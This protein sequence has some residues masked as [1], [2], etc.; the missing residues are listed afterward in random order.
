MSSNT[1]CSLQKQGKFCKHKVHEIHSG[2]KSTF[3]LDNDSILKQT[4]LVNNLEV[5]TT[6][7]P[8]AVTNTLIHQ[9][10]NCREHQGCVRT[11]NA[12]KRRFWWKGMRMNVKYHISN[13]ITCSKNLPNIS[14][15]S[16]LH[17]EI[18]KIP[19]A[20]ITINTICKLPTTISGDK[21]ALTCINR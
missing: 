14:C 17:L 1:L 21:Y 4:I 9:F 19:V 18:P 2:V 16:Q 15:H 5:C 20:C 6:V 7:I 3:Y 11:L 8:I 12:L 13:C 10:H